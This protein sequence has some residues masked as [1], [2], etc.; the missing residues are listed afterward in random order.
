[1]AT[2]KQT[3]KV[4]LATLAAGTG[5]TYGYVNWHCRKL[6]EAEMDIELI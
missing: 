5:L 1:M 2:L 6:R 3:I 4:Y